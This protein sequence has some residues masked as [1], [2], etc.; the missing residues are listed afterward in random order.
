M[1]MSLMVDRIVLREKVAQAIY[2]KFIDGDSYGFGT[3]QD[4]VEEADAAIDTVLN[5]VSESNAD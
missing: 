3:W 1:T 5:H 4:F 2:A